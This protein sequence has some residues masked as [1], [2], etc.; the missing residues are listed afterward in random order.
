MDFGI[1]P[2]AVDLTI[3]EEPRATRVPLGV[4]LIKVSEGGRSFKGLT[5]R[6]KDFSTEVG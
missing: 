2:E 4:T 6:L 1:A 3:T 5:K